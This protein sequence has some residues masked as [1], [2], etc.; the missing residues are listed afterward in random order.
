MIMKG[1]G[2]VMPMELD[3]GHH[4]RLFKAVDLAGNAQ[5]CQ[6][7]IEVQGK[8]KMNVEGIAEFTTLM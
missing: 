6:I 3:L 2:D 1:P 8:Y 5:T 7:N 4:E